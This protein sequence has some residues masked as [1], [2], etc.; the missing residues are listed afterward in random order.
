MRIIRKAKKAAKSI[1]RILKISPMHYIFRTLERYGVSPEKLTT[2][3]MFGWNGEVHVRDVASIVSKMEIWEID[4]RMEDVLKQ[5][6]PK[7]EI[8][9][10]DS[11]KEIK[12][13]QRKFD[14]V[15][16]DNPNVSGKHYEH[17]D[18]FPD[19]FRV[20]K[21][22]AIIVLIVMPEITMNASD[23]WLKKRKIFYDAKSPKNITFDEMEMA[24]RK[25]AIQCRWKVE[26]IF[27]QTRWNFLIKG[28][29]IYYFV[30]KITRQVNDLTNTV[31]HQKI[32]LEKI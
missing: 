12:Q 17:F 19:I 26:K 2:L 15:I 32:R 28:N 7:A 6:F 30:L 14:V 21:D 22:N 27:F 20:L 3:E 23:A 25:F 4:P 8:K 18:L 31:P 24:Y 5:K 13:T 29:K 10:T 16:V 1:R 9:I 11:Y